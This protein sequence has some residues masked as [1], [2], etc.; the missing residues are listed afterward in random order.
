MFKDNAFDKKL[1]RIHNDLPLSYE[2]A[3]FIGIILH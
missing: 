2:N 1:H 3:F